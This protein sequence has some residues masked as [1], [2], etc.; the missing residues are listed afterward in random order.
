MQRYFIVFTTI[1]VIGCSV[2]LG[3]ILDQSSSVVRGGIR[4]LA[5]MT[6]G[7]PLSEDQVHA[8][9][10]AVSASGTPDANF[11]M[12]GDSL[13]QYMDWGVFLKRPDVLNLGLAGDTTAGMLSRVKSLD[14]TNKTVLLM[15]GVNDVFLGIETKEIM[16]NLTEIV[17]HLSAN[18]NTVYVQSTIATRRASANE[19]IEELISRQRELCDVHDCTFLDV[20]NAVTDGKGLSASESI[21]HVHL[22]FNGYLR[23]RDA[24]SSVF[25]EKQS[26]LGS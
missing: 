5:W 6:L 3:A 14:L 26:R 16:A 11:V 24:L 7:K 9:Y 20:N 15:G 21:D 4:K 18:R 17:R 8:Q 23:W 22:N 2:A 1:L 25:T 12:L 13:T 19:V 10:R